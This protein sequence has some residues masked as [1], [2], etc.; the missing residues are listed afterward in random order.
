MPATT[1]G[2]R[3]LGR[4]RFGLILGLAVL[5]VGLYAG[6]QFAAQYWAYWN[7]KEEAERQT[8]DL[9][10]RDNPS[11]YESA[12]RVL[13]SRA[14]E[15]DVTLD[16]QEISITSV[17]GQITISFSFDRT[18]EVPGYSHPLTFNVTASSRRIRR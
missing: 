7:L 2:A 8:L 13:V 12:R 9:A 11:Q 4:I 5:A 15:F 6:V 18:I 14:Q 1:P 16:P 17:S 10:V 3:P